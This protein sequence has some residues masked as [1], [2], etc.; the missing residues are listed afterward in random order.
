MVWALGNEQN[1][2]RR[3]GQSGVGRVLTAEEWTQSRKEGCR[4][5][6]GGS[7]LDGAGCPVGVAAGG[8]SWNS[9]WLAPGKLRRGLKAL[10]GREI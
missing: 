2:D 6:P 3:Q 7:P 9:G 1:L 10:R 4:S 5:R 8:L